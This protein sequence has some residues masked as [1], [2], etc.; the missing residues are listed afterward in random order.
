MIAWRPRWRVPPNL[1]ETLRAAVHA[2]VAETAVL[3]TASDLPAAQDAVNA[4]LG[5]LPRRNPD[6][7]LVNARA[8]L[9]LPDEADALLR[10]W[11]AD[12]QRI[13]R[14]RFLKANLYDHPDLIVLEQLERHAA[15]DLRDEHVAEL[16]RLARLIC[17]CDRW[18]FPLLQQWEQ[19]GQGFTDM[20]K[21]QQAMLVLADSIK[22]L[23]G[24][25]L[26][27]AMP[28]PDMPGADEPT[29]RAHP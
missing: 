23:G 11:A 10:Q 22:A 29:V 17:S 8:T 15:S 19:L 5:S 12:R 20:E 24:D 13:R 9:G 25:P 1:E 14:L 18:W 7:I 6:Y 4:T 21:R 27:S 16:Q 2:A 3:R 28:S 26:P